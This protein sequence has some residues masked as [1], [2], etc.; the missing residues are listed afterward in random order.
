MLKKLSIRDIELRGKRVFMRVDFNVP[1]DSTLK[2]TDDTRIV[3]SLPTIKFALERGARLILA[4]HLGRPKGKVVPE[5]SLKP[6]AQRLSELLGKK[7]VMAPDSVGDEVI[8]LAKALKDGDVMLL[9]NLRF[10]AGET[11]NDPEFSKSLAATAEVYVNDAFGT[12]HRAHSS[13]A[14]ITEFL[15]PCAAGLLLAKEIDYF[16]GVIAAPKRPFLALL[17][18]AKVSTKI[19]VIENL[20]PKVDKLLIGGG[21]AFTFLKAGGMEVGKSLLETEMVPQAEGY[22]RKAHESGKDLMLPQ[23]FMVAKEFNNNSESKIVTADGIPAEWMG[24]DIGPQT[25]KAWSKVIA[26]AKTIVW[27]GPMGAFEMP[28]FSTGTVD[29]ARAVANSGAVSI[30]GGGD[31]VAALDVAGVR[32]KISHVSTGGGASLDLLAGMKLP[33]IEALDDK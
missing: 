29:I 15:S 6:A 21:M 3:A 28:S 7:V 16:D 26:G 23:D 8:R 5:M 14:G 20:L 30:V 1:L 24:L 11:E 32:D 10:H 25:I 12:A 4:S 27:N 2:I 13:T 17:G 22:L 9:E 19:P 33:G 18:G 31:S